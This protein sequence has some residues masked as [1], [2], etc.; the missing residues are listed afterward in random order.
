MLRNST[1]SYKLSC[2]V[3]HTGFGF[4]EWVGCSM[5][6]DVYLIKNVPVK[7]PKRIHLYHLEFV[8][9]I[10]ATQQIV[11]HNGYRNKRERNFWKECYEL[12][13]LVFNYDSFVH[14]TILW[15]ISI[16]LCLKFF[17]TELGFSLLMN[18]L[19]F[20]LQQLYFLREIYAISYLQIF[21]SFRFFSF[22]LTD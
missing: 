1:M 14:E 9:F 3:L 22:L 11:L 6:G 10:V 19:M 12:F 5:L 17:L 4:N 15:I 16:D 2:I 7:L 18:G 20:I 21:Q 8:L 13:Q